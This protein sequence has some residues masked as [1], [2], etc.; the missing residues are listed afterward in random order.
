MLKKSTKKHAP[1]NRKKS[2]SRLMAIQ[3]FYQYDYFEQKTNIEE[4]REALIENYVVDPEKDL[5]SYRDKIDIDFLN[6]LLGTLKFDCEKIDVE[7][8]LFL[9]KEVTMDNLA[10]QILR[11]G[12]LELK[13]F[14]EIPAKVI[15]D[16]YVDIGA[17]FFEA[18]KLNFIN[19]TLD[20][21]A[22]AMRSK[23]FLQQND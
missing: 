2:L 23:E 20:S 9:K 5:S 21:L 18:K 3:I 13:Y 14:D 12:A 19:A 1:T 11:F 4:I 15:L 16:E 7:M 8:D 17:S 6:K 22:K 10:K